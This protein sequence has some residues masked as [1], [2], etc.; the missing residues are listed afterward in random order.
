MHQSSHKECPF[1]LET[2][3]RGRVE[4]KTWNPTH[5]VFSAEQNTSPVF[6]ITRISQYTMD[7]AA[8]LT[9]LFKSPSSEMTECRH[10][11]WGLVLLYYFFNQMSLAAVF[12]NERLN[13]RREGD[14]SGKLS[15]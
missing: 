1:T 11:T 15:G 8:F 6:A 9:Y 4:K 2:L 5:A 12:R 3:H 13:N 10:H 14:L 7:S